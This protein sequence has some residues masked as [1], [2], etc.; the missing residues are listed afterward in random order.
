MERAN[1]IKAIC[2]CVKYQGKIPPPKLS[3]YTL[4]NEG[5][6]GKTGPVW[7]WVRG[8]WEGIRTE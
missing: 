1:L 8:R 6:K 5:E 4:T 7:G 3:I 2:T